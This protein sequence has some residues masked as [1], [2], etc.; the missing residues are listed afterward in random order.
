MTRSIFKRSWTGLNLEFSFSKTSCLSK[1]KEPSLPYYLPIAGER[2]IGFISS[3]VVC[4]TREPSRNLELRTFWMLQV[5]SWLQASKNTGRLNTCIR[6][7]LTESERVTPVDSI[8]DVVW[9]F[10]KAGGHIVWNV[11]EI[12]I[13]MKTIVWKPLIINIYIYIYIHI[14]IYIYIYIYKIQFI[15]IYLSIYLS[16]LNS[17]TLCLV[18][19][20]LYKMLPSWLNHK[21][22]F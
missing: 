18:L 12:T 1:A 9:S 7:W 6:L 3:S 14:Y 10:V 21:R 16:V 19:I 20:Y 5:Q 4:Q 15:S 17:T 8:K 13:K 22:I 11:V 2:I